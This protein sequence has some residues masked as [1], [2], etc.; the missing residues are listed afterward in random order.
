[1]NEMMVDSW[2]LTPQKCYMLYKLEQEGKIKVLLTQYHT[3]IWKRKIECVEKG[4]DYLPEYYDF[5]K[6]MKLNMD[7]FETSEGGEF[8]KVVQKEFGFR[9]QAGE[10]Q[11][12][13][14]KKGEKWLKE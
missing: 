2:S 7:V 11:G 14:I 4:N 10:K 1:M 12:D 9:I 5:A 8:P 3:E 6:Q 13:Y